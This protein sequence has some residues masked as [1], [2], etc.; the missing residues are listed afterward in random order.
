MIK[1]IT[2]ERWATSDGRAFDQRMAAE[3]H[4]TAYLIDSCLTAACGLPN[5]AANWE[6]VI[7]ALMSSPY[8]VITRV[9]VAE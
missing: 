5:K 3:T 1:K 2:V 4:E 9:G 6:E 7:K 8:F